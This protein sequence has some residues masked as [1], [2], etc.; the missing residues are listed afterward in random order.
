VNCCFEASVQKAQNGPSTQLT[1]VTSCVVWSIAR[2]KAEELSYLS[3]HQ[4]LTTD[5]NLQRYH[6]RTKLV[7]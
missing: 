3:S 6:A 1:E 5:K 4:T 2:I 7:K